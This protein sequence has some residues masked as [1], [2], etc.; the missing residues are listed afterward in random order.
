MLKRIL[1]II[2]VVAL[3]AAC[4]QFDDSALQEQLQSQNKSLQSLKDKI[5]ALEA[6]QKAYDANLFI[7]GVTSIDG[8]YLLSFSD[9]SSAEILNGTDGQTGSGETLIQ[10][11]IVGDS[12]VKFLLTDGTTLEIPLYY[13]L[14]IDFDSSGSVVMEAGTVREIGYTITSRLDDISIEVIASSDLKAKVNPDGKK[15]GTIKVQSTG[16]LDEFSKVS[17]LVA[18]GKKVIVRTISFEN[19]NIQV[20]DGA[21]VNVPV[22]GGDVNL[23]Y[24]ANMD[25]NVYI[26]ADVDWISQAGTK[27]LTTRTAKVQV[28]KNEGMPRSAVVSVGNPDALHIDF[29]INQDS[30]LDP[31]EIQA[32][33]DL[34]NSTGGKNWTRNDNWCSD[35]PLGEWY[36][37]NVN[38]K[39]R[40]TEILL[41][42]NGLNGTIPESIGN[43]SKLK[44]L[45]LYENSLTGSIPSQIGNLKELEALGLYS[46][47][48][49]GDFPEFITSLSSLKYLYLQ[50]N[51]GITG[52]LPESIGNL[53]EL[54]DLRVD[55]NKMSGPLPVNLGKLTKLDL[56]DFDD[57]N[58]TGSIPDSYANLTRLSSLYLGQNQLTGP[59][60]EWIGD[61]KLL[62]GLALN[63]NQFT[64]TIPES[65]GKLDQ[66]MV[67]GLQNNPKLSGSI[68]ESLGNLK[69]VWWFCL[70]NS[71]LSGS[72]PESLGNLESV[73]TFVL[74]SN[75]FTGQIPESFSKLS[76]VSGIYLSDNNIT[77]NLPDYLADL[78]DLV[79]LQTYGNRM[80][81]EI[82]ET[83]L[84]SQHWT[85]DWN[86]DQILPQQPGYGLT[87][88]MYE[89]TDFSK[90]GQVKTLQKHSVGNG[91]QLIITGD[92]FVD[93]DINSGKFDAAA[94]EAMED[95]FAVEPYASFRDMFDVYSVTAVSKNSILSGE[96]AMETNFGTDTYI[97]GDLAKAVVYAR[98]AVNN[99]DEALILVLVN[100]NKY[101]GTCHYF[102]YSGSQDFG[103]GLSVAFCTMEANK[104]SR[105]A[106]LNHEAGGH[107]F[108]KLEDEYGY[109]NYGAIPAEEVESHILASKNGWWK[110]V[111]FTSDPTR[112][113][114]AKYLEDS[115]Y[116]YDGLGVFEG[117]CT[118]WT[119]VWRPT[120][121]SIMRYNTGGFNAPSR[122]AIWYRLHKLA[123]GS[124]WN[125]NHEEFVEYDA[126][127][128]KTSSSAPRRNYVERLDEPREPLARPVMV[129]ISWRELLESAGTTNHIQENITKDNKS[130][131]E[132]IFTVTPRAYSS[133]RGE[134][135]VR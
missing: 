122:E 14:S 62:T 23:V 81:G 75:N 68:P 53:T 131:H 109:S 107:G 50:Y 37:V 51:Y 30:D 72:I 40:V 9:G 13:A 54:V 55:G 25:F 4:T 100:K 34:Y 121:N 84:D 7:T 132:E 94:K 20:K 80:K 59:I 115:R 69:N 82:S 3:S 57:N 64:G 26:P 48:L 103:N 123:Y 104:E 60:P 18:N 124:G 43:L 74:S 114:W 110:N 49:S 31:A 126:K 86:Q 29:T 12:S 58:F 56:L 101:A 15:K 16:A 63:N 2:G 118:Y 41:N 39:G 87:A 95:F 38:D 35:R 67:L 85:S 113:K 133:A 108:A 65:L 1:L 32:L 33:I 105:R 79:D 127:N 125:Y 97:G 10:N 93:K 70:H 102:P 66:L 8:G 19:A 130:D 22:D 5:A 128:R 111:D 46:N 17:V 120:E 42:D 52:S 90:D 28:S 91:I 78:P 36:G 27:A 129:D 98:K 44:T 73:Q 71:N 45:Y 96:T 135:H 117:G 11:I 89:S 83:I 112:V 47:H 6:V 134:L 88:T 61:L 24:L 119:G 77:G 76:N 116:S 99:L 92:A 21:E 106:T